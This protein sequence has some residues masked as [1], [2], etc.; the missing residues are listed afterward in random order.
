MKKWIAAFLLLFLIAFAYTAW[1]DGRHVLS[2]GLISGDG[3]D[4]LDHGLRATPTPT[5]TPTPTATPTPTPTPTPSP[6]PSPTPT[7]TPSAGVSQIYTRN[8]TRNPTSPYY[9]ATFPR[10]VL[11]GDSILSVPTVRATNI[12]GLV[13]TATVLAHKLTFGTGLTATPSTTF[14]GSAAITAS[15]TNPVLTTLG[16]TGLASWTQGDIPYY[17]SGT[18][19]SRLAKSSTANSILTNGG[20]SNNPAWAT[21]ASFGGITALTGDV[22]ATGPGSVAA[23]IAANAVTDAKFRQSA[24]LSVVGRSANTTGNVADI[25][26]STDN[27][28]LRRSGTALGFGAVNLASSNGVTG[29]LPVTNLNSGTGATATTYWQGDGTWGTPVGTTTGANPTASSTGAAINGSSPNFMRSDAAPLINLDAAHGGTAQT[30]YAV[31]DMLYCAVINTLSKLTI[32]TSGKFLQSNGTTP[33]WSSAKFPTSAGSSGTILRSNG[34]DWVAS[35]PTYPNAGTSLKI[36][37]GDGT[38]YVESTPAY[39]NASVTAGKIIRSDGTNYIA[40]TVTYPD[41]A[42]A[43]GAIIIGN[44]TNFLTSTA[45]YP[46]AFTTG[47]LFSASATNTGASIAAVATGQVLASAGTSTLPAWSATPSLT[48]LALKAGTSSNF[49][50]KASGVIFINV[51]QVGNVGGGEDDLMTANILANTLATNADTIRWF[52]A[53]VFANAGTHVK[54]LKVYWAGTVIMDSGALAVGAGAWSAW[55]Y[56]SR[57]TAST[58]YCTSHFQN[59]AVLVGPSQVNVTNSWSSNN[60][61]KCTGTVT[62][63]AS[64]NDITQNQEIIEWLTPGS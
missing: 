61:F 55:G 38:N 50:M 22:T 34:T 45:L 9:L 20:T 6:T 60:T 40:S 64:D 31:G 44:G 11:D 3:N 2:Q 14:D 48:S 4:V 17:N 52:C 13:T 21:F 10:F 59:G 23:T 7:A 30:S 49:A 41:A 56:I 32:G 62:G 24:G 39:P 42:P 5:P 37:I 12:T 29:N 26:A 28:V 57:T 18:A 63:V 51:T 58:A 36:L 47:D 53:G 43:S 46:N 19:L 33:G 16:G 15:L 27:N 25:T 1:A 54:E 8:Q 35:T